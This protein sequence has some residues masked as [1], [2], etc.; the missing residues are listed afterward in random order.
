MSNQTMNKSGNSSGNWDTC[1]GFGTTTAAAGGTS[2]VD[3]LTVDNANGF[4]PGETI[5]WDNTGGSGPEN[6]V[7]VS[8]DYGTDII[9]VEASP[10]IVADG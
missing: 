8:I 10:G 6:H 7:I 1:T 3:T 9:T 5:E 4:Y 2:L